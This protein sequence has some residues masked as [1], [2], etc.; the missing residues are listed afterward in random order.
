[1]Q[2][3]MSSAVRCQYTFP[4]IPF[5]I[6]CNNQ[7]FFYAQESDICCDHP[8]SLKHLLSGTLAHSFSG[9]FA[10]AVGFFKRFGEVVFVVKL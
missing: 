1:M 7:D 3:L 8:L 9:S 2:L 4:N 5:A 6:Y 10:G